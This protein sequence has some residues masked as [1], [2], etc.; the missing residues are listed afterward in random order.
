MLKNFTVEGFHRVAF[1]AMP[2]V[3]NPDAWAE[4][5][6]KAKDFEARLSARRNLNEQFNYGKTPSD[7]HHLS[8]MVEH[9]YKAD[10]PYILVGI[11]LDAEGKEELSWVLPIAGHLKVA[12]GH[13]FMLLN[14]QQL[15]ITAKEEL[16]EMTPATKTWKELAD[17]VRASRKLQKEQRQQKFES[18][19]AEVNTTEVQVEA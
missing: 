4:K 16:A 12:E 10:M 5:N 15:L 9:G 18:D 11:K 19:L 6:A 13:S 7:P 2:G 3:L 14:G 1:Y 8:P 17:M